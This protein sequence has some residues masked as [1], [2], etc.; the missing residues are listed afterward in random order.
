MITDI[1][2][3]PDGKYFMITQVNRPFSY[4]VPYNSF[5]SVTQIWDIKGNNVKTLLEEP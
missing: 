5:P 2:P 3:S 4:I 1:S